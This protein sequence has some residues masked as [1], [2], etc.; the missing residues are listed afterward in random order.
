[1]GQNWPALPG[2]Y[3]MALPYGYGAIFL[4]I[5]LESTGLPLPGESLLIAAAIYAATTHHLNIFMLVP[6][7]AAGAIGGDQ[8][9][10]FLGRRI[11]FRVLVRYGHK[12][13]L[14]DE[15]LELGRFLFRRHGGAVVFLG[16]F[17]AILRTF[18]ALLAG[19]NRMPW[20]TFLLWNALGGIGW[21]SLYGF[22]A[23]LLGDAAKRV[24]GPVG[25]VLAVIGAVA[26]LL[27]FIFVKR[28]ESRL[29]E[30]ARQEMTR[31][32]G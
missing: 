23:Y 6:I 29:M 11:G 28:N 16:R 7:A 26:L 15:R 19:A 24:R 27:A 3:S 12:I 8:I 20:H 21:T 30:N 22:G 14:S 31:A 13:G 5:L 1:V 9:G 32:P 2:Q 25:L 4:G 18:A 10:Y 17:V